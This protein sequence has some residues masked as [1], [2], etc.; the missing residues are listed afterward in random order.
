MGYIMASFIVFAIAYVKVL[1]TISI[2]IPFLLPLGIILV[3]SFGALIGFAIL[4][5]RLF[6]ISIYIK[7]GIVYSLLTAIIIFIF[8]YSQHLVATFLGTVVEE[9]SDYAHYASIAIV[10]IVFMPLKQRL[11]HAIEGVFSKKKIEL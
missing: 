1:V 4:K 11:E 7:I 9:Y 8:D 2:D 5:D 3:D 10:I 6:D